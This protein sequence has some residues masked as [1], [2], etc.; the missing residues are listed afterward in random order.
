METNNERSE[1]TPSN[2]TGRESACGYCGY[3]LSL[4]AAHCPECGTTAI[5]LQTLHADFDHQRRTAG[6]A[7][8]VAGVASLLIWGLYWTWRREGD[9]GAYFGFA[10]FGLTCAYAAIVWLG[11]SL[12]GTR[13]GAGFGIVWALLYLGP[14]IW[15]IALAACAVGCLLRPV[16]RWI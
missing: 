9:T 7:L 13:A 12:R 16:A 8:C 4:D 10:L 15:S 6:W 2:A 1:S 14:I 3:T 11:S 5:A